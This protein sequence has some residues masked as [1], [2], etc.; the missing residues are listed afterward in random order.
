MCDKPQKTKCHLVVRGTKQANTNAQ[1]DLDV[2]D[3][4]LDKA[5]ATIKDGLGVDHGQKVA[6]KDSDTHNTKNSRS[7]KQ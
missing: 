3:P 1:K 6:F 7:Q 4:N 5:L 2:P